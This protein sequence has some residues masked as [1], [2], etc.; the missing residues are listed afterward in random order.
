M[1][2]HTLHGSTYLYITLI[3][4]M[5]NM[6]YIDMSSP[7]I[8]LRCTV[9]HY[10]P[11]H[12][13]YIINT[14]TLHY[15]HNVNTLYTLKRLHYTTLQCTA[16]HCIQCIYNA[17]NVYVYKVYSTNNRCKKNN[18]NNTYNTYNAYDTFRKQIKT[19][20]HTSIHT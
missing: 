14:N 13:I 5:H 20:I 4:Y 15:I 19:Y 10:I 8:K 11:L 17:C 12:Y 3:L 16:I 7:Y 9:L 18:M 2:K 6:H 1:C